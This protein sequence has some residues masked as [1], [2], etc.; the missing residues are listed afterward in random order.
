VTQTSLP[1]GVKKLMR[2][3]ADVGH[4][5]D[6]IGPVSMK[7]T[8][9]EPIETTASGADPRNSHAVDENLPL[10]ERAEIAGL[11]IAEPDDTQ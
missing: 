9:F 8:E 1:S 3:A 2:R 11:R 4:V 5:L 10:V 6:R 7:V